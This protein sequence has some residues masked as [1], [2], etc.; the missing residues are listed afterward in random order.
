MSEIAG[1]LN[2][3]GAGLVTIGAGLGIGRLAAGALE[4]IARQPEAATKIQT[5]MLITA[6]MI[7]GVAF[8]AIVVCFVAK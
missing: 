6:A 3:I 1:S 5:G 4:G 2:A 7:E 8:V